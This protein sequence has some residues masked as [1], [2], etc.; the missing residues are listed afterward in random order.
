MEPEF[1]GFLDANGHKIYVGDI[2]QHING[3]WVSTVT[4]KIDNKR[5]GDNLKGDFVVRAEEDLGG[6]TLTFER[7]ANCEIVNSANA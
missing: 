5:T 6:F 2:I 3:N 7:A 4:R 1:T